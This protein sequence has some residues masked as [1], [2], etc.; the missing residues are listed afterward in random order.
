MRILSQK[1]QEAVGPIRQLPAVKA[2][3]KAS[4]HLFL[5]ALSNVYILSKI[6]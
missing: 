4:K 1:S 5:H 6:L 3:N 2:R